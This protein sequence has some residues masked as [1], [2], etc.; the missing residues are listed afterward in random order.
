MGLL[1]DF[2]EAF[3]SA[4]HQFESVHARLEH[5]IFPTANWMR[6]RRPP[7]GRPKQ[8]A[9]KSSAVT[10]DYELWAVM[11]DR[12]RVD[13]TKT[14]DGQ[15][16]TRSEVVVGDKSWKR[17]PDGSVELDSETQRHRRTGNAF[18]TDYRRHFDRGLIREFFASLILEEMDECTIAGRRCVRMRALPIPGD[19]LWPHWLPSEAD[20]FEFAGDLEFPCLLAITSKL[21][22]EVIESIEA[23]TVA[24]NQPVDASQFACEPAPGQTVQKATPVVEQVSLNEA[25]SRVPFKVLLPSLDADKMN[26][27]FHLGREKADPSQR[28]LI[29]HGNRL[30]ERRLWFELNNRFD[31]EQDER[32]EWEEIK[33]AGQHLKLSDP[34]IDGAQ[35][36]LCFEKEGTWVTIISD[37]PREELLKLALSFE[38]VGE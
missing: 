35:A 8:G 10:V 5:R 9:E 1:G 20:E 3:Y 13:S 12:V 15:T 24:F 23:T 32:L 19:S 27:E 4:S 16:A 21:S 36:V 22:G 31:T 26:F 17:N 25:I 6:S 30:G 38:A 28:S 14:A 34:Q 2:L 33:V 18:P 37:H 11:P 7:I 29:A